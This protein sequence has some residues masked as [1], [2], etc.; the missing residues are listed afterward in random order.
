MERATVWKPRLTH[1]IHK[2]WMNTGE[3]TQ[4]DMR[5][6][7]C[8]RFYRLTSVGGVTGSVPIADPTW[9]AG[10]LSDFLTSPCEHSVSSV[11]EV[12]GK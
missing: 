8:S 2:G 5:Q 1:D 6:S 11:R 12:V 4:L 7:L 3:A 10:N 9:S